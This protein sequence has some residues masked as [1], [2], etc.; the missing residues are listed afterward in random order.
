[1]AYRISS[2]RVTP[3]FIIHQVI[4]N[5]PSQPSSLLKTST[6][7]LQYQNGEQSCVSF[8]NP[9]TSFSSNVQGKILALIS[10]VLSGEHIAIQKLP[11]G[12]RKKQGGSCYVLTFWSDASHQAD[13]P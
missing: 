2:R 5:S 7:C 4:L 9:Q 12:H 8:V 6:L 13:S 1:M 11:E 10:G 3:L